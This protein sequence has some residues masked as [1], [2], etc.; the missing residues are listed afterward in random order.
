MYGFCKHIISY[1]VHRAHQGWTLKLIEVRR[2][3]QLVL[4]GQRWALV[5]LRPLTVFPMLPSP[6][7]CLLSCTSAAGIRSIVATPET[8]TRWACCSKESVFLPVPVF[9]FSINLSLYLSQLASLYFYLF[10]APLL[11]PFSLFLLGL[12][13]DW[14]IYFLRRFRSPALN[15][16]FNNT[17]QNSFS[18]TLNFSSFMGQCPEIGKLSP[19]L[20]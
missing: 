5:G 17:H 12:L 20:I 6:S 19:L 16:K 2:L 8:A 11:L 14:N 15:L 3:A 4:A 13:W 9:L 1:E 10:S 7:H 18:H